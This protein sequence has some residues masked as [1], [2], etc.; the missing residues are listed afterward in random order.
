MK[1]K[2]YQILVS[3]KTQEEVEA[4]QKFLLERAAAEAEE[5]L[6]KEC[7]ESIQ[8]AVDYCTTQIGYAKTATI[9]RHILFSTKRA[10]HEEEDD[11]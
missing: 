6:K 2:S 11:E 3:C 9:L 4:L 10:A 7:E 8:A 1:N 5:K